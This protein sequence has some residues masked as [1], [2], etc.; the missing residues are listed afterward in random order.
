M[1]TMKTA[2]DPKNYQPTKLIA[3]D[4]R[5][6][7]PG[8]QREHNELVSLGYRVAPAEAAPAPVAQQPPTETLSGEAQTVAPAA[9]ETADSSTSPVAPAAT[10]AIAPRG[11]G[12]IK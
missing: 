7:T 2:A 9:G 10:T 1:G 5:E 11:K 8:S 4:G 12:A 6:F 3:P